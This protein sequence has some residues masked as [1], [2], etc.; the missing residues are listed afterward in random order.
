[1]SNAK[2][3]EKHSVPSQLVLRITSFSAHVNGSPRQFMASRELRQGD[4][5]SPFLFTMVATGLGVLLSK[6]KDI[7]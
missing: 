1:M 5:L 7:G 3:R 6:D 2:D 4:P